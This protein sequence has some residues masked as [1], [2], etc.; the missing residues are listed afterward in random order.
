M[1]ERVCL[2]TGAGRGIGRAVAA[3]LS[4]AGHPVALVSR[5]R[6]QLEE[7]AAALP[8][9]SMVLPADLTD[10]AAVEKVYAEVETGFGAVEILVVSSGAAAGAP[11]HRTSDQLWESILAVNLTAPFRCVRRAVPSMK[12]RGYGRIVVIGSV[13]SKTGAPYTSAYTASKHGVLGLVRA[14]A[15]ELAGSGVTANAV[16]PGYVDTPMTEGTVQAIA[17]NTRLS[18]EQARERLERM[19]PIG[20]LIA[21]EE[22]ARVVRLLVDDETGSITGQGF[23][24]DGGAVMS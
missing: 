9:P 8:G 22:V 1:A 13:L 7:T 23:N 10:L 12:Q 21:V 3:D 18:P 20:R 17:E 6:D 24:V 14:V 11:I 4:A 2:V 16:C 15:A 19:Q 5:S